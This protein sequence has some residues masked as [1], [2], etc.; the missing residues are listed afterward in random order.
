ML[1]RADDNY[2]YGLASHRLIDT[3]IAN[4]EAGKKDKLLRELRQLETDWDRDYEDRSRY[5]KLVGQCVE[6]LNLEKPKGRPAA[7]R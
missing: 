1:L 7:T 6:R 3:V 5:Q 2:M 4:V